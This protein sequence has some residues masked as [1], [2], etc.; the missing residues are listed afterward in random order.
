MLQFW[1]FSLSTDYWILIDLVP[2]NQTSSVLQSHLGIWRGCVVHRSNESSKTT[3][4]SIQSG[5]NGETLASIL[6]ILNWCHGKVLPEKICYTL[7]GVAECNLHRNVE[8]FWTLFWI[9]EQMTTVYQNLA[10]HPHLLLH[11]YAYL[12]GLQTG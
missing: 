1:I 8:F 7:V 5:D 11:F 12:F 9:R 3:D 4:S 10:M 2:K 6:F